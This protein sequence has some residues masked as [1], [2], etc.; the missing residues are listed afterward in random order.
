MG[1]GTAR[2]KD[3]SDITIID[4]SFASINKAILW[5]RSIYKNIRRFIVF[6][7]IVNVSACFIVLFGAFVGL[8]SPLN[9]MQML[10]VNLIMDTFAALALSTIPPDASVMDEKPRS[11]KAH[12]ISRKTGTY[13][14]AYGLSF[15]IVLAALWMHLLFNN[16]GQ[17]HLDAH[18][19][20][21]FFSI[22][23]FL[24]LWNL[25]NTRYFDS[26]RS[27]FGDLMLL[28]KGKIKG[29]DVFSFAFC[30]MFVI[31]LIGQIFIVEFFGDAF[32]VADLPT[33]NG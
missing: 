13:I 22:F 4:N 23:V 30:A 11:W 9:V 12:I 26:K 7:T 1:D 3:A 25:P 15:F 20:G 8:D 19:L 17:P 2:A 28:S 33:E 24:Q 6:Q 21:F 32:G 16:E 31:I 14:F 18:E 5:G 27:F 10:W 29:A